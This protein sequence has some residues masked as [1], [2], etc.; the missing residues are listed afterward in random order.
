MK[1][2][3]NILF[4][5]QEDAIKAGVL[6]MKACLA[7]TEKALAMLSDN[8]IE[9]PAKTSLK[10]Y[11][12]NEYY[13]KLN[14]MPIYIGG[15]IN[16]PGVKWAGESPLNLRTHEHPMGIDIMILSD[17]ETV[18]PVCIMDATLVTAMRTS[19]CTVTAAKYMKK[20]GP[21]SVA[22]I[23]AGVIGRTMLMALR[24]SD[25]EFSKIRFCDL[26]IE[27]A[28]LV[29]KG[30]EGELDITVTDSAEE[31]IRGADI[32]ITAT[33][34]NKQIVQHDWIED[35]SVILQVGMNEYPIE[36]ITETDQL[37]VDNWDQMYKFKGSN[38]LKLYEEG[39]VDK[40]KTL[41][42]GDVVSGK[43]V[44]RKNDSQKMMYMSR[45]LGCLDV[46][47]GNRVYLKAKEM[48]IGQTIKLWDEPIWK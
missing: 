34:A 19:S 46:M 4:L 21:Q 3:S 42:L 8:E 2:D 16:R 30:F 24:D 22:L 37:V 10:I 7:D 41:E 33:T 12:D 11:K 31:A 29:A 17:P 15:D 27:K 40:E 9:N 32:V 14:S 39:K 13:F 45:G 20:P 38:F 26:D 44:A 35:T 5:K 47:V 28:K 48:G 43:Q 18:L 6:D 36:C 25:A 23:G 1:K